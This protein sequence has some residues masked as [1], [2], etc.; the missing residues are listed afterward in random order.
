MAIKANHDENSKLTK[1]INEENEQRF[2]GVAATTGGKLA[3]IRPPFAAT[4][5]EKGGGSAKG[6]GPRR[7]GLPWGASKKS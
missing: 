4:A 5:E 1:A 7:P 3:V 6:N 2:A